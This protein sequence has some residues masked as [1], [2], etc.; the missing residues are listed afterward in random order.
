MSNALERLRAATGDDDSGWLVVKAADLALLLAVYDAAK[1]TRDTAYNL[2]GSLWWSL[3]E[4]TK[5][6]GEK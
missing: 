3:A 4:L 6:T 1:E 2:P 5:D